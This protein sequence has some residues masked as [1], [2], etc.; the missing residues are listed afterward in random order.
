MF[1]KHEPVEYAGEYHFDVGRDRVFAKL[2]DSL[3]VAG[4]LGIQ[5]LDA[6]GAET[7]RV[8]FRMSA[9]AITAQESRAIAFDIGGT[10]VRVFDDTGIVASVESSNAVIAASINKNGWFCVCAQDGGGY[11]GAVTVYNNKG[12]EVYRARLASGYVLSAV[13]SHDNKS[14]SVLNLTDEGSRVTCY[15]LNS[16]TPDHM[17]DLPGGLI[18]DVTY[19][20][21]GDL[22]A[23][24]T[25]SLLR[26]DKNGA[27]REL[28]AYSGGIL[29]GYTI[30][31]GYIALYLLDY[32]VG[33][34]GRL[35]TLKEDGKL[36]SEYRTDREIISM[37]AEGGSLAV[38]RSDGILF[39]DLQ[40]EG[41]APVSIPGPTAGTA[42]V[43]ALGG[44]AALAAG[45]NSAVVIKNKS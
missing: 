20:P 5:V 8:P 1:T 35:V 40:L 34:S 19:L 27:D 32:G 10:A 21:G 30:G 15:S 22:L 42:H 25:D 3:A 43:L 28:C 12:S 45:D 23:V 11:K 39:F 29:G 31:G 37:S 24:S 41:E 16:E 13:L 26:I 33:F 17:F 2:G 14:L 6:E 38:L 18:I 36:L 44:G 7:L 4:T 9:P